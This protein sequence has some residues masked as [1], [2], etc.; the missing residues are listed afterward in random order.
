M[1]AQVKS[2]LREH[3]D[4][5]AASYDKSYR[6]SAGQYF[7]NRKVDTMLGLAT[8]VPGSRL[9]EVGCAS[10]VYTFELARRGFHV[11]G[12]DLSPKCIRTAAQKAEQ[13]G[14][15]N[16]SFAVGD[17]EELSQFDDSVF[18]GIF[19]FST[20]RYV[21]DPLKAMRAIYRVLRPGGVAVV[22]FPNKWSPWFTFLKPLVTGETHIHDHQYTTAQ[23][24]RMLQDAG[25][26]EISARRILYTH[27]SMPDW[28]LP[29]M[30]VIDYVGERLPGLNHCA[31]IIMA[32]GRK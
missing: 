29:V 21:S 8:F 4:R 32:R 23:V 27:K 14:L 31:S 18:D 16:V 17:A 13:V 9:L 20:L 10:G 12:L 5:L 7:M 19:S 3:Y 6:R 25:F 30:K 28:S 11:T 1:D 22:D 2:E 26:Q 15:T 24:K